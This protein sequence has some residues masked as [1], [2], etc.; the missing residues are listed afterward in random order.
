MTDRA[1]WAPF[2]VEFQTQEGAF[3]FE[4][5]AVDWA[6]ALD[7]LEELKATARVVGEKKDEVQI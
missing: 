3:F 5:F 6:H 7:R 4:L 1:K 2:L